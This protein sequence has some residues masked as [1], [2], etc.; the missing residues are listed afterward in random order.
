[1]MTADGVRSGAT[2]VQCDWH[3]DAKHWK[4]EAAATCYGLAE[5]FATFGDWYTAAKQ[6]CKYYLAARILVDEGDK[7]D[8]SPP[9]AQ[10]TKFIPASGG[11]SSRHSFWSRVP[12]K[13]KGSKTAEK[14]KGKGK[15]KPGKLASGG[16]IHRA[17]RGP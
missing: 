2:M 13:S 15:R 12:S 11:S 16:S 6:L 9:W 7:R 17:P 8:A 3:D 4:R 1:M 5:V 14:G 10:R